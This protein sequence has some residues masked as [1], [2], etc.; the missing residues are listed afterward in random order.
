MENRYHRRYHG[1]TTG[2]ITALSGNGGTSANRG[3]PTGA[4]VR[5][6]SVVYLDDSGQETLDFPATETSEG[7][8]GTE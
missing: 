8:E 3:H 2:S 7:T 6:A 4:R 1:D 5:D